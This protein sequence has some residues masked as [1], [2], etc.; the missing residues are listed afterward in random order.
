MY[1]SCFSDPQKQSDVK[2]NT[3]FSTLPDGTNIIIE[4]DLSQ[5]RENGIMLFSH[6]DLIKKLGT[7]NKIGC[8]ATFSAT[9]H[10]YFQLWI[11]HGLVGK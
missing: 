7:V 2:L 6:P 1:Y 4:S 9:P 3:V 5:E 11:I 10:L 8:D